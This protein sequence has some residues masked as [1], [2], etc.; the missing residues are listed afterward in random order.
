MAKKRTYRAKEVEQVVASSL[1]TTLPAAAVIV[2]IDVGKFKM[3]AA[4]CDP[5]G[6]CQQLVRFAFPEQAAAFLALLDALHQAGKQ[7]QM[8]LEPTGTYGDPLVAQFDRRGL[9]VFLVSPKRTH[10]AKEIF[11][12]VPS[13]HDPKDATI[14]ARLHAQGLSRRWAPADE[15]RRTLRALIAQREVY[16]DP[17]QRLHD[18]LEPLL[19]RHWPELSRLLDVRGSKSPLRLLV[20]YPDPARVRTQSEHALDLL[21]RAAR[22]A[23]PSAPQRAAVAS[24]HDTMG[25]PMLHEEQELIRAMATEVLRLCDEVARLDARIAAEVDTMEALRPQ[26]AMLGATTLAV[27]I[28]WVG[29]LASY[30]SAG[31]LEKA[32]GLNLREDSSG[33]REGGLHITKRGPS[34]VRKYLYLAAL[35]WIQVD[36]CVRAWYQRRKSYAADM[37]MRAVV[38]VMRKLV[39]ALYAMRNGDAYQSALLFDT[40]RLPPMPSACEALAAQSAVLRGG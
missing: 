36:P 31:A 14:L 33:T 20:A 34:L 23:A 6:G 4:F 8:V 15:R 21:T 7:L 35:R 17:L 24:A 29:D 12:G 40:R 2:A 10:D 38:A 1:L 22:R 3:T 25:V 26:R 19:A 28:A 9:P 27:L 37:K 39:R 5:S 18:R 30:G 16:A 13:K 32:C 11:D